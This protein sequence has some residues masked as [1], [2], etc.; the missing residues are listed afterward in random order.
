MPPASGRPD[1]LFRSLHDSI[2]R[3]SHEAIVTVDEQQRIVMIN[4]AGQRMFGTT[5]SQAL[6]SHLS[7]FIPPELRDTHAA[8]VRVFGASGTAER[9]MAE[10]GSVVGLRANGERFAAEATISRLDVA[11]EFGERR[12]FTAQLRDVSAMRGLKAEVDAM[13]RRMREIFDL[14]PVAIWIAEQDRVVFAN[15]ACDKLFGAVEGTSL[16]GR[17][18]YALLSEESHESLRLNMELA[19]E[20][21]Q[22]RTPLTERIARLDGGTRLVDIALS[23][24]WGQG[25]ALQMVITDVTEKM[26]VAQELER[27]HQELRELAASMVSS[28]EEE[29][30]RIAREMHDELGRRLSALQIELA[31][32]APTLPPGGVDLL[33]SLLAMVDDTIASVRRIASELRPLMLDDLGLNAAVEWLAD[34]WKRR[35]GI[36]V[37]LILCKDDPPLDDTATIAVY[38][39][40]QEALTNVARHAR[41]SAVTIRFRLERHQLCL[42]IEDNGVGHPAVA[43]GRGGS[44]G[45]LGIRERVYMAGG[46][47]EIGNAAHGGARLAIRFPLPVAASQPIAARAA[48]AAQPTLEPPP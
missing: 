29:R 9:P 26:R 30:L 45:L 21:N 24:L 14:A 12:Y 16:V 44:H 10:R 39:I 36:P 35:T 11:S 22:I 37:E 32:L 7:C 28:R 3:A 19:L 33:H 20:G 4:P 34:N 43:A 8:Q 13:K 27:S 38:R 17:S 5:A 15:H 41:A 48:D 18:V 23:P 6:G 1:D 25:R 31:G 40:V 42:T 47:L 46:A 2:V